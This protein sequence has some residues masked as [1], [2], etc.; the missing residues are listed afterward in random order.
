MIMGTITII[1][2]TAIDAWHVPLDLFQHG[3]GGAGVA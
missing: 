3:S 1:A 2:A